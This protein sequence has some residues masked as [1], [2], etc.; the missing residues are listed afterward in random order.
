MVSAVSEVR[1]VAGN[2]RQ[3]AAHPLARNVPGI[4]IGLWFVWLLA[5]RVQGLDIAAL[6]LAFGRITPVQWG[7]AVGATAI[8]LRAVSGYDGLAARELGYRFC[9]KDAQRSG[10]VATALAQLIGLG[11]ATGALARW[12]MLKGDTFTLWNATLLTMTVTGGFLASAAVVTAATSLMWLS[13]PIWAALLASG[14]LT[15]F[16]IGL[17]L[18]IIRPELHLAERRIRLPKLKVVTGFMWLATIDLGWAAFAFWVLLPPDTATGFLFVLPVVLLAI[19]AGILSGLPCGFGPFEVTIFLF[20]PTVGQEQLLATILGFRLVYYLLRGLVAAATLL[21][22]E[23]VGRQIG[24]DQTRIFSISLTEQLPNQV[25]KLIEGAPRA[26]TQL[27]FEGHYNFLSLADGANGMLVAETGNTLVGFSDPCTLGAVPHLF[28][29]LRQEAARLNC[30]PVIYKC[31]AE[32]VKHAQAAGMSAY[33]IGLEAIITPAEFS[34]DV[35]G[36]SNLRRKLRQAE[37][38]GITVAAVETTHLP[39]ADMVRVSESWCHARGGERGF[40]MGRFT[41]ERA[42][43]H[44]FF[45]AWCNGQMVG[46][47]GLFEGATEKTL[48]LMRHNTHA[49]DGTMHA[50]VCAALRDAA[51]KGCPRFSLASVPLAG[52]DQPT[53]IV[54]RFCNWIYHNRSAIHG[55]QGL[56]QFKA[57][58]RPEFEQ[59]YLVAE[60]PFAASLSGLDTVRCIRTPHQTEFSSG[61]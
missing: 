29:V 15:G 47:I 53:N 35:T 5:S 41:P 43:R 38:A 37:R 27:I 25:Q 2:F 24:R 28:A 40:S 56:Y 44:R 49:P 30:T 60:G 54:E 52:L 19:G 59:R 23:W 18:L 50:L 17:G 20:L 34:P 10:F 51:E 26:E 3:A 6:S 42:D 7:L 33:R 58:F 48:D 21:H 12:R 14:V 55:A 16:L 22:Q 57:S 31:G 32:M 11:L 39:L 46:F 36:L 4:A 9:T 13:L 45:L 1:R 61:A 8:S